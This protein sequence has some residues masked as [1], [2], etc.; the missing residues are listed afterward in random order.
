M[1]GAD[2]DPSFERAFVPAYGTPV[3]V[4]PG[5]SRITGRNPSPFTFHG[6]NAYVAGRDTCFIVDPGPDIDEHLA[7]ILAA[8]DGRRVEAILLTH[9][10]RDHTGLV[11]RLAQRTGAP[12]LG[13]GPH[14]AA[15]PLRDGE[16]SL[17]DAA[18]DTDLVFDRHLADGE[19]LVLGG[20]PVTAIAT[21]GHCANHL[22]YAVGDDGV[23]LSG[24]HVMAWSTSIVAP[25]DGSMR[26]YMASLDRLLSRDD[27]FYLPGHGGPVTRPHAFVRGLIAHRRMRERAILDRLAADDRT[28]PVIV[29]AIYRGTDPSLHGAAGYSVLA[30][31]EDLVERGIVEAD[32][33]PSLDAHYRLVGAPR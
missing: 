32:E 26:A 15:R 25:P 20:M 24:D 6:T 16:G 28:I 13:E 12:M 30:H 11:R 4:A 14:R 9:T 1:A 2:L 27:R 10:H 18:G 29:A 23:V 21:P 8:V 3:P 31:L 7:A 19:T 17:L 33:P 22:A 5:V